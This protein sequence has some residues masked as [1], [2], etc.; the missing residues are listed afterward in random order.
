MLSYCKYGLSYFK[1]T[2][3]FIFPVKSLIVHIAL[4]DLQYISQT[5]S[6]SIPAPTLVSVKR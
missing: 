3:V 1:L 4:N 5:T 2:F 6:V